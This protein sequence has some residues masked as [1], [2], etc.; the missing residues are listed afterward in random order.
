MININFKSLGNFLNVENIN[1]LYKYLDIVEEKNDMTVTFTFQNKVLGLSVDIVPVMCSIY[2]FALDK[3]NK[4]HWIEI[5]YNEDKDIL[6]ITSYRDNHDLEK[7]IYL[8]S[9]ERDE[10]KYL[11]EKFRDIILSH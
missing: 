11:Y 2:I 9:K 10:L 6:R 3:N 4:K 1:N 8:N 7:I 5:F